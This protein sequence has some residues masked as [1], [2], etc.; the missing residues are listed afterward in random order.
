MENTII[1]FGVILFGRSF[2]FLVDYADGNNWYFLGVALHNC[3]NDYALKLY[4]CGF[5]FHFI[6]FKETNGLVEN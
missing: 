6:A 1:S 5:G 2:A 4:F 3:S